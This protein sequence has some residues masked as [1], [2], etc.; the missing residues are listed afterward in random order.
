MS[1]TDLFADKS[2]S[3]P[4]NRNRAED[5][6]ILATAARQFAEVLEAGGPID[7][8][9]I[10]ATLTQLFGASDASGLWS[11]RDGYDAAEAAQTLLITERRADLPAIVAS[12]LAEAAGRLSAQVATHRM[13]SEE[14]IDFQQFST[15]AELSVLA[16]AAAA[17]RQGDVLLDPSAGT[18]LLV[19][20][21]ARQVS[22]LQLNELDPKRAELLRQL[23]GDDVTAVDGATISLRGGLRPSL[24]LMNP[25]FSRSAGGV[26]DRHAGARH[27]MAA[28][29][30]LADGGRLVAIMPSW[31]ALWESGRAGRVAVERIALPRLDLTIPSGAFNRHGTS[32]DTRLLVFDKGSDEPTNYVTARDF[33]H[34]FE[35][36]ADL[37]PRLEAAHNVGAA[38]QP[39]QRV[40]AGPMVSFMDRLAKSAVGGRK[41]GDTVVAAPTVNRLTYSVL[42]EPR[43]AEA[44][45]GH[46]APYRVAR[47]SVEGATPH[48]TPLVESIAM[49]SVVPPVPTYQTALPASVVRM[50]S[51]P[52][53]ETVIYAGETHSQDLPGRY[54]IEDNGHAITP[55]EQGLAYRA[56]YFLADGTGAGKGRQVAG[57]ILDNWLQGRRKHVWVSKT[58][59]L[60]EDARRD[61]TALGGLE[62][63]IRPLNDWNAGAAIEFD[64]GILFVTYATL[65]Q[66]F[67][68]K[69]SRLDQLL[70]NLGADFEGVI[71]FDEAHEMQNAVPS[72][73]G[74]SEAAAS[75][76]GLTGYRLQNLLPRA[77]ILYV[78]ATGATRSEALGYATRLG[79]WGQGAGFSD[80]AHFLSTIGKSGI[81]GMEVVVRDLKSLGRYCARALSF[82]GVEYEIVEHE[83]TADQVYAYNRYA[84]FWALVAQQLAKTLEAIAV[85][86]D[87]SGGTLNGQALAA[88]H[89]RFEG[90]KLRF[91]DAL[92]N[93]L[94]L[95]TVLKRIHQSLDSGAA[96]VVQIVT[97]GESLLN[98]RSAGW[99]GG[100]IDMSP[101]DYI[102]DYLAAWPTKQFKV[103]SDDEG[104]LRSEMMVDD[105][106]KPVINSEAEAI[107]DALRTELAMLPSI[108]TALDAIINHFGPEHVAEVTGRSRRLIKRDGE[109]NIESRSGNANL[110]ETLAFN[111]DEK[112]ILIFSDAGGTGRSY[113]ADR[114]FK[115]ICRRHHYLVQPG[116]RADM[117]VQGLGRTNRTNQVEPP[118][119][120]PVTTNVKGERRFISTIARRLDQLGALT[121]GQRETGGQNLFNPADNLESSPAKDSLRRW[122]ELL[123]DGKATSIVLKDFV[124]RTGLKLTEAESGVLLDE[125]PPISRFL[126]RLLAL[127]IGTQNRIFGEFIGLVDARIEALRLAGKLDIGVETIR[128]SRIAIEDDILLVRDERTAAETRLLVMDLHFAKRARSFEQVEAMARNGFVEPLYVHNSKSGH[129]ALVAD[130]RE[131]INWSGSLVHMGW[132]MR[133]GYTDRISAAALSESN[134]EVVDR[135]YVHAGWQ[136][137]ADAWESHETTQRVHVV[138]GVLLPI[139]S[140]L[141]DDNCQVW[142]IEAAGLEPILGRIIEP[143]DMAK[144]GETFGVAGK[145]RITPQMVIE[146]IG[147]RGAR[148]ELPVPGTIGIRRV[149]ANDSHRLEIDG[150]TF[151]QINIVKTVGA[152]VEIAHGQARVFLP[153][154]HPAKR[155]P[156]LIRALGGVVDVAAGSKPT[157][158]TLV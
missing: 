133:A 145:V 13:R 136:A 51:E 32:V 7:R 124:A 69:M 17:A 82:A 141:P 5:G 154:D 107:R 55:A 131:M 85:R 132:L 74:R 117:A 142:R 158:D 88:A 58:Q 103:S 10:T 67:T 109:I 90:V 52:Q 147:K 155:I 22:L 42:P 75:L 111:N 149:M 4:A 86:D 11:L 152:F 38:V 143:R 45:S 150:L 62:S 12:G 40:S 23:I 93:A 146:T 113:H 56:G 21:I 134:W 46:Y 43:A 135:D 121:R 64:E 66:Q 33:A 15:P 157:G 91:F 48:P 61:W 144:L 54:A 78:S 140:K 94:K 70:A 8:K 31:F 77:R 122:F 34:G 71:A 119:L 63:D 118:L 53:I 156:D 49:A 30:H 87:V 104:N 68:T 89:S 116:W 9:T 128:A 105:D 39:V 120:L 24:I 76:Q 99:D 100:D 97:T 3:V 16:C 36:V 20:A 96:A 102:L 50:L 29:R 139:W 47:I 92:L 44:G 114:G 37:P 27:L 110:A 1:V 81:A 130:M 6:R 148:I 60:I 65:R 153:V 26:I 84:A 138:T 98:R 95:P 41:R 19:A 25:P 35:I 127:D 73:D 2:E 14:Q 80:R 57:I 151:Q 72:K 115:N 28:L 125:T 129:V 59:T 106:G 137:D 108:D 123:V 126:N 112:R 101:R 18:G 79:L 83:L